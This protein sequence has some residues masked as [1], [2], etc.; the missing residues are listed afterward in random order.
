MPSVL[1]TGCSPGGI[2]HAL[3][4]EY[5]LRGFHVFATAR[6]ISVLADLATLGITTLALDVT[7]AE[8]VRLVRERVSE[9]TGGKLDVLVNNAGMAYPAPSAELDIDRVRTMFET[10]VL[11]VMRMV[12]E[13]VHLLIAAQGKIITIGSI[14]GLVPGPFIGSYSASKAAVH[15]YGDTL[16]LELEPLG[17]KVTS[18]VTGGVYSLMNPGTQND[19]VPKPAPFK[20]GSIYEPIADVYVS[21]RDSV[22]SSDLMLTEAYARTVIDGTS[23]R[24]PPG[25]IWAGTKSGLVYWLTMFLPHAMVAMVSGRMYG[26]HKWKSVFEQA[27]KTI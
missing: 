26:V 4:K 24:N 14:A 25:R 12:G 11:G 2:G 10:N 27:K 6:R 15:A 23:G 21:K 8:S 16:R 22:Q 17:V 19:V 9:D 5:H 1:I 3:A 13:F 7:N 18:V 20:S